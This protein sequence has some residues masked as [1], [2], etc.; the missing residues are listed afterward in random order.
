MIFFSAV[1]TICYKP[2]LYVIAK[3]KTFFYIFNISSQNVSGEMLPRPIYFTILS[4]YSTSDFLLHSISL[5]SLRFFPHIWH[6]WSLP[7]HPLHCTLVVYFTSNPLPLL[8]T[9]SYSISF[10]QQTS[11][12][13]H[14]P[15]HEAHCCTV[16][17]KWWLNAF[18]TLWL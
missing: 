16:L 4:L 13:R 18:T 12:A 3:K 11:P 17:H 14:R 6:Q 8:L 9:Q 2:F 15:L 10:P 7:H 5:V 1:P